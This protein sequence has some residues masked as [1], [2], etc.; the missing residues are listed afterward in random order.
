M[1]KEEIW[2]ISSEQAKTFFQQQPDVDETEKGFRFADCFVTVT[3]LPPKGEG[4]WRMP[5]TKITM[6]GNEEDLNSIYRRFFL[7]FLSAGG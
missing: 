6:E 3:A 4:F 2:A 5:Q 7:Q 1:R